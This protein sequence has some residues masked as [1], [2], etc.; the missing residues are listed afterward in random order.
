M[1][2]KAL[3]VLLT[4]VAG[5][6]AGNGTVYT[7]AVEPGTGRL[8]RVPARRLTR[9]APARVVQPK[10]IPAREIRPI[11][12]AGGATYNAAEARSLEEAITRIAYRHGIRPSFVRAVIQAESNYN[13]AAI[14]P[15]GAVGLMQLMPG[16][17][18]KF[19]VRNRFDPLQNLE[20]G[21]RYLR[22]LMDQ[23]PGQYHLVL[24]A[25]NAGESAV[26]RHRGMPP[27]R[28]TRQFVPRVVR[29]YDRLRP[30]DPPPA[31]ELPPKKFGGPRITQLIDSSGSV[32]YTTES[33]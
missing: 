16:T 1:I 27:Y 6:Y 20:G 13:A 26:E 9:P 31:P 14:S 15:K 7:V 25:Y 21:V 5:L 22:H 33:P 3:G 17:A 28:E 24:A 11:D 18:V 2:L 19:G 32:R 30:Y 10:V 12:P 23:Y 8:V 4:T 29:Y